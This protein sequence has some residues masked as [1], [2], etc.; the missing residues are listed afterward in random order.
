MNTSGSRGSGESLDL[1][2]IRPGTPTD[3]GSRLAGGGHPWGKEQLSVLACGMDLEDIHYGATL[4]K[5]LYL[6]GAP[7]DKWD[8]SFPPHR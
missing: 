2:I 6:I 1:S 5:F 4:G 8:Y 7:S 3:P